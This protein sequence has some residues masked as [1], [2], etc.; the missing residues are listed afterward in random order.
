MGIIAE[1]VTNKTFANLL[2]ELFLKDFNLSNTYY[3]FQNELPNNLITG[4]DKV[5]YQL[6]KVNLK[7][8]VNF[9]PV[10]LPL[11]SFTA[12]GIVA[13][14]SDVCDFL[15][16]LIESDHLNKESK[17]QLRLFFNLNKY[18]SDTLRTHQG[19]LVG[20]SNFMGYSN[21]K[22]YYIVILTN[23]TNDNFEII[24]K[25][26]GTIVELLNNKL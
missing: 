7:A 16:K 1:K 12:G 13:N 14:S 8:N 24:N 18:G 10:K 2:E 25:I 19:N 26:N 11:I 22:N 15:N 4:Y 23:L 3:S 6:G 20:Y 9:F 17:R 5:I 21:S